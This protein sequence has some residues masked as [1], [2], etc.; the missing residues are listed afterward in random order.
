MPYRE[1]QIADTSERFNPGML[2]LGA[3]PSAMKASADLM[4]A[5]FAVLRP[6][7]LSP[8]SGFRCVRRHAGPAGPSSPQA[9]ATRAGTPDIDRSEDSRTAC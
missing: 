1:A 9:A 7:G 6:I 2:L 3:G 5:E 4:L 8:S